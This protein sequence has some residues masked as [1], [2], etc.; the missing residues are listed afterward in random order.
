[1]NDKRIHQLWPSWA[2]LVGC[3]LLY[4]G[5]RVF[6]TNETMRMALGISG[7]VLVLAAVVVRVNEM[8]AASPDKKPVAQRILF[9][10][11]GVAAALALYGM[12]AF[13]FD[14]DD[15]AAKRTRGTLWGLWPTLLVVSAS[16]LIALEVAVASVAFNPRYS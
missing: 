15:D 14:G 13:V 9:A 1:M 16:P 12:I 7:V 10:T 3:V 8:L 2:I 5:E 11:L 4:V 6:D